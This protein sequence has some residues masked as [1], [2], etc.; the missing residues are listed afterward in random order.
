VWA[1]LLGPFARA[2][3]KVYGV[4]HAALALLEPLADHLGDYGVGSIAEVFDADAPFLP[5][6]CVAQAWSVA[7]ILRAWA[8]I[9]GA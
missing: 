7:E 1:W 9:A 5:G 4:R 3:Y 2:H 6:G 8:E